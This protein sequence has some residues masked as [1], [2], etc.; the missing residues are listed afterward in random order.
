MNGMDHIIRIAR[1]EEAPL[2][3][4]LGAQTFSETF[5]KD[6]TPQDL[7]EYLRRNFLPELQSTELAQPGSVFLILEMDGAPAGYA[8]LRDLATD[9]CL[10]ESKNFNRLHPMEL[11]RIYLLQAWTGHRLG[12]VLMQACLEHARAQGV[13]VLWLGV[14]E[15]NE[16]AIAFYKRWGFEKVGTHNFQLGQDLQTDYVL[17]RRLSAAKPVV[18]SNP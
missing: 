10:A 2:L 12:D 17:A 7:A 13:E 3:A 9:P 16:R 6:N 1:T 5:G 8:R 4:Q 15:R 11:V 14:W 18:F